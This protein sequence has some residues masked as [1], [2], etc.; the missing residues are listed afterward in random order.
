MCCYVP[1][2][3]NYLYEINNSRDYVRN[4]FSQQ[5]HFTAYHAGSV[6]IFGNYLLFAPSLRVSETDNGFDVV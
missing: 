2:K 1:T 5:T 3:T 6:N 4:L